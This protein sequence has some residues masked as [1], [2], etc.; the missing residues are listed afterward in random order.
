MGGGRKSLV[1]AVCVGLVVAGVGAGCSKESQ[2]THSSALMVC[3]QTLTW[4][5]YVWDL[6]KPAKPPQVFKP[7]RVTDEF[8]FQVAGCSTG[9]KIEFQPAGS[10]SIVRTAQA[11]DGAT[12]GMTIRLLKP[13]QVSVVR[14]SPAQATLGVIDVQKRR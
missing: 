13:V 10:T 8:T 4:N 11:K 5:T 12:A 2:I 3:G 7:Y 1:P 6:R 9:A 14:L